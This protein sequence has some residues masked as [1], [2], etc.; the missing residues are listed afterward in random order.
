VGPN[1]DNDLTSYNMKA[2]NALFNLIKIFEIVQFGY[3]IR[4]VHNM[5]IRMKEPKLNTL[6]DPGR[7]S[8]GITLPAEFAHF[9]MT[10]V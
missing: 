10:I 9:L 3:L 4:P 7:M 1:L 2:R 6:V 8:K 5:N